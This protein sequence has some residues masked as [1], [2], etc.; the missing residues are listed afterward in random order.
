MTPCPNHRPSITRQYINHILTSNLRSQIAHI[1]RL[2]PT[3][4]LQQ[5]HRKALVVTDGVDSVIGQEAG[6]MDRRTMVHHPNQ[7]ILF[8][9]YRRLVH[10]QQSIRAPGQ[11]ARGLPGMVSQLQESKRCKAKSNESWARKLAHPPPNR[12]GG[13]ESCTS[14]TSSL[15]HS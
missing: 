8:I 14:V 1:P 15:W 5:I 2:V 4:I 7:R 11:Q 3:I 12:P 9:R 13:P 6:V 10:V